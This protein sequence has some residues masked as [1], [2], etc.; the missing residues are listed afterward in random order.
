LGR[1]HSLHRSLHTDLSGALHIHGD[2][3]FHTKSLVINRNCN[4]GTW[5]NSV[6]TTSR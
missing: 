6:K 4:Y 5:H 1:I 2:L 3:L